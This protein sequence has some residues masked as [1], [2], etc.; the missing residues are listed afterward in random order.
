MSFLMHFFKGAITISE[1]KELDLVE[2]VE[3]T[4]HANEIAAEQE[5]QAKKKK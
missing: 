5:R 2:V 4:K 3:L 1:S